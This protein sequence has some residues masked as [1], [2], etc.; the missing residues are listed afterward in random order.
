MSKANV[1]RAVRKHCLEC[2]GDSPDGVR[3]CVST[4]CVLYPY[5]FGTDPEKSE[6]RAEIARQR[7]LALNAER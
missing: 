3:E 1:L 6:V 7:M 5:R 4:D 2:S